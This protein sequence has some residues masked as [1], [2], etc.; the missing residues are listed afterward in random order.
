MFGANRAEL[1]AW[2]GRPSGQGSFGALHPPQASKQATES[3][4]P[5]LLLKG[6]RGAV[7]LDMD[8]EGLVSEVVASS[9]SR[10]RSSTSPDDA[11]NCLLAYCCFDCCRGCCCCYYYYD[12]DHH[13]RYD[14]YSCSLLLLLTTT[15]NHY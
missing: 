5:R 7:L 1:T 8:R 4:S 11:I 9:S 3:E 6:T 14:S 10:R 15:T 13:H 12:D 2:R